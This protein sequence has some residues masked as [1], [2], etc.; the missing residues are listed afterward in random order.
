M[1]FT[2]VGMAVASVAYVT[3]RGR[4]PRYNPL[5]MPNPSD[6]PESGDPLE[7]VLR[8]VEAELRR[9]L[10]EACEAEATGASTDTTSEIRRLEDSLLA[11]AIAAEQTIAL[12]R[13]IDRR[14]AAAADMRSAALREAQPNESGERTPTVRE[15]RDARGELWRAWPVTPGQAREGRTAQRYLGDFQKGWI[16][17]EALESSARRRLPKQPPRWTDLTDSELA[18]LLDEAISAPV[19]KARSERPNLPPGSPIH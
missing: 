16:C 9:Y 5:S 12:R 13:H 8:D 19:R 18:G 10:R 3:G 7:P 11:A 15:F 6:D 4:R 14:K 1:S 2:D 17:F